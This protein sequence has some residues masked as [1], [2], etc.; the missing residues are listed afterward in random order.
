MPDAMDFELQ[1]S[2]MLNAQE[3]YAGLWHLAAET[4]MEAQSAAAGREAAAGLAVCVLLSD[5]VFV[6]IALLDY[7]MFELPHIDQSWSWFLGIAF[8]NFT[9]FG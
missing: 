1:K 4:G 9:T 3:T 6:Q 7:L 2:T 8:L 5:L